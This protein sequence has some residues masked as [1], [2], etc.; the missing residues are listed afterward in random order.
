MAF[1]VEVPPAL[2]R[3]DVDEVDGP[4]ADAF[5]RNVAE[6]GEVGGGPRALQGARN[7]TAARRVLV[8]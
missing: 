3:S 4:V 7:R 2:I 8:A 1:K 6:R 5:R